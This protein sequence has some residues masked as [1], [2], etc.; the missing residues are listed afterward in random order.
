MK[1]TTNL[2]V[3]SAALLLISDCSVLLAQTSTESGWRSIVEDRLKAVY[4]RREFKEKSFDAEWFPDSSGY[5]I[6]ERDAATNKKRLSA[7]ACQQLN[8]PKT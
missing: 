6:Q 5:T 2:I 4:T 7:I 8:K 1:Y 3:M